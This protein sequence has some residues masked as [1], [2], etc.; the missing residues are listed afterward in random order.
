VPDS[1]HLFRG[2]FLVTLLSGFP[3]P[4]DVAQVRTVDPHTGGDEPFITGLTSAIDVLP[5]KTRGGRDE[6]S[7]MHGYD[8]WKWTKRIVNCPSCKATGPVHKMI[9]HLNDGHRW[10][11]HRIADW[12][13]TIEPTEQ[14]S[15]EGEEFSAVACCKQ[16]FH[17]QPIGEREAGVPWI[18]DYFFS[19]T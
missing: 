13:S 5:A 19:S 18:N 6:F 12:I 11:R 3:F 7:P 10:T 4:P 8:E 2:Q 15:S 9:V 14:T 1:I 17:S 16:R